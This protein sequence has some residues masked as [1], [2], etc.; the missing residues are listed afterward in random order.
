MD[1]VDVDYELIPSS[2]YEYLIN[3]L[4]FG[5]R[6]KKKINVLKQLFQPLNDLVSLSN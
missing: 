5:P 4:C 3:L 2:F 1:K 6:V